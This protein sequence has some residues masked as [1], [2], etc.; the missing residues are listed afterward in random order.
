MAGL[1]DTILILDLRAL[2][3]AMALLSAEHDLNLNL[4]AAEAVAAAEVLGADV[5][6]RESEDPG[7]GRRPRDRLPARCV[8]P[9][10]RLSASRE[11]FVNIPT[12]GVIRTKAARITER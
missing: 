10:E 12:K 8:I 3:P 1:P 2:I 11:Q 7:G 9:L 6:V 4:L 5:V